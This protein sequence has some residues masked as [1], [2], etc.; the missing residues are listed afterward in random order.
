MSDITYIKGDATCPR[1]KGVKLI[2]HICNDLGGWGKGF[3]LAIS[4]R[5]K[6]P[7][8]QYRVWHAERGHNGFGLGAVQFVQVERYVWVANMVAQHGMRRGS[9]GPPIRYEAVGLCLQKVADK[10]KE[11]G[12]SIHMPRIGCGLASGKWSC[13]EPLVKEH[14]CDQG[15]SVIVYDFD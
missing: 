5:W 4:N 14:L 13:I 12:A 11:L 1:A 2:C 7:D 9:T 8:Q 6:E 3:V 15:L 10:A